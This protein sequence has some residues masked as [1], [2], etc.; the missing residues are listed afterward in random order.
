MIEMIWKR[1]NEIKKKNQKAKRME[2]ELSRH[3]GAL[4]ELIY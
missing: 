2:Y 3:C 1:E 4:L